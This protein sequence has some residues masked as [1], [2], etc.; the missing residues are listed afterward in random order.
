MSPLKQLPSESS[1]VWLGKG[2][3]S[4]WSELPGI[5]ELGQK[6]GGGGANLL[7]DAA[8]GALGFPLEGLF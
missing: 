8:G 3:R 6:W 4:S 1:A 7:Q 5:P 2:V